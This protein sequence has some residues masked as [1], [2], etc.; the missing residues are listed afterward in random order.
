MH[1]YATRSI[2]ASSLRNQPNPFTRLMWSSA[3]SANSRYDLPWFM[4]DETTSNE[5]PSSTSQDS[6]E[7]RN[8]TPPSNLPAHLTICKPDSIRARVE[9]DD[10][11]LPYSTIRGRRK[12]GVHDAG[13]SIGEP[14]D[15]WS[16]YVIAEVKEGTEGRGA[17]ETVVRN[18]QRELL[19]SFP[20]L[21]LPRKLSRRPAGDGWEVLDLGD[22]LLHVVS[23]MVSIVNASFN[24]GTPEQPGGSS[25]Q[26][27]RVVKAVETPEGSGATVFRTIGGSEVETLDPFLMLDHFVADHEGAAFP[28]HPHRGQATITYMLQGSSRHEDSTGSTGILRAGD[29]QWMVAGRGVKHAE[30]P[31]YAQG[32]DQPIGLQLWVNLAKEHKMTAPT[33]RELKAEHIPMVSPLYNADVQIRIISGSSCGMHVPVPEIGGC[34]YLHL[35]FLKAQVAFNQELPPNTTAFLYIIKGSLRVGNSDIFPKHTTLIL[36]SNPGEE[37]VDLYST[38][39]ETD[40]V[41]FSAEPLNQ[42]VARFGPFVMNTKDELKKALLDYRMEINGFENA[43][44]WKSSIGGR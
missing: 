17:I 11:T 33:Y 20:E 29:V 26:V 19:K 27:V 12:R 21:P 8:Q 9:T 32:I 22:S 16:W 25:R 4:R 38:S 5:T 41:L 1:Y 13:E 42:P 15:M 7:A 35:R 14:D 36:S 23:E 3:G 24:P 37:D 34:W 30:M 44:H 6:R 18:A 39:D 43:R 2:L 28:D 31:I 10:L 40:L